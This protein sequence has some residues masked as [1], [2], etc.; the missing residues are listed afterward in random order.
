MESAFESSKEFVEVM[1]RIFT[2]MSEDPQMGPKLRDR[3]CLEGGHVEVGVGEALPLQVARLEGIEEANALAS[4][5]PGVSL[6]SSRAAAN[7]VAFCQ[8]AS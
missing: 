8:T 6:I 5:S 1:D 2:M 4:S 7:S 3:A